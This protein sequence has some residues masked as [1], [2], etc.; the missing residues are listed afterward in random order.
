MSSVLLRESRKH[1]QVVV[2]AVFDAACTEISSV[3]CQLL[4]NDLALS[5]TSLLAP[6]A[7]SASADRIQDAASVTLRAAA[8]VFRRDIRSSMQPPPADHQSD[9]EERWSLFSALQL[10]KHGALLVYSIVNESKV[11]DSPP[12]ELCL[13]FIKVLVCQTL[14]SLRELWVQHRP[15]R[16]VDASFAMLA[17]ETLRLTD[18]ARYWSLLQGAT[19]LAGVAFLLARSSTSPLLPPPGIVSGARRLPYII[20]SQ[21]SRKT[22]DEGGFSSNYSPPSWISY[23]GS[24]AASPTTTHH[25]RARRSSRVSGAAPSP[26]LSKLAA[27]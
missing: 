8:K 13:R 22:G 17:R 11:R 9:G 2:G 24:A 19:L 27:V 4:G 23:L 21:G 14:G 15:A 10:L 20:P 1:H 6:P 18:R 5:A 16:A 3:F 12:R 25:G 7:V 26:L